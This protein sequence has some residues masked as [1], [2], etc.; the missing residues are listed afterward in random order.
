MATNPFKRRKLEGSPVH[1]PAAPFGL[2]GRAPTLVPSPS[3]W[4][5]FGTIG[6]VGRSDT[7]SSEAAGSQVSR[8]FSS[9]TRSESLPSEAADSQTTHSFSSTRSAT[10]LQQLGA[11]PSNKAIPSVK[12]AENAS[13]DLD[14]DSQSYLKSNGS[15]I[16]QPAAVTRAGK[17]HRIARFMRT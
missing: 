16:Q 7:V 6:T 17:Q 12:Q 1:P 2:L 8:S 9:I 4:T 3:I 11:D 5:S 13:A 15:A 10:I 14:S